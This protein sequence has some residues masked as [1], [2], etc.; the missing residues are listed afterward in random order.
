MAYFPNGSALTDFEEQWCEKC[1]H[2]THCVIIA[3]H[4]L[5]DTGDRNSLLHFLI[6]T[7]W[8]EC[9]NGDCEM[10]IEKRRVACGD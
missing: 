8:D 3:A 5:N 1:H 6:P 9:R 10:F 2:E 7:I 4:L